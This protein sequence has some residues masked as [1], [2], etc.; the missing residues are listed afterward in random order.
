MKP[1]KRSLGGRIAWFDL[2][3]DV[4]IHEREGVSIC[5][6]EDATRDRIRILCL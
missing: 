3:T 6:V 2:D 4:M 1:D 5:R